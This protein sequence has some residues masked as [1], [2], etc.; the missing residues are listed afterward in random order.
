MEINFI[1]GVYITNKTGLEDSP[2]NPL[3]PKKDF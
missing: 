1:N 3:G 2:G